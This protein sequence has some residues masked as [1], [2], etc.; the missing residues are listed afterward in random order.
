MPPS[1]SSVRFGA[2]ELD[3]RAG[4][5]RKDGVRVKLQEKPL[6]IL[7]ALL[8]QA[9]Q[10]VARDELR[11]LLWPADTFVDFEGGLN[12]AV[13]K[14]RAAL[15]D[16]AES[17]RFIET[18][19]RRGY[20]FIARVERPDLAPAMALEPPQRSSI[21]QR[22]LKLALV[23]A[24]VASAA[25]AVWAWRSR[26][27]AGAR[28]IRS[29]AV[30]PFSNFSGNA[31]EEYFVD[32][33]TEALITDLA[34]IRSLRVISRQSVMRYKGSRSSL[35]QIAKELGV[36]AVVEGSAV[37]SG[38]RVRLTAQLIDAREESHIWAHSYDRAM[39]DVLGLQDQVA[40]AIADEVRAV[41]GPEERDHLR[42]ERSAN[43]EA[44]DLYLR[45][46]YF[47]NRRTGGPDTKSTLLKA[48]GSFEQA[49]QKDPGFAV[50]YAALAETWAPLGYL[51][52]V[53]P[54]ESLEPMMRNAR[55]AEELDDRLAEAHS[56]MGACLA[57]HV[58]DWAAAEREFKRALDLNPRYPTARLWYGLYLESMGRQEENL[59]HR[60]R[61]LAD[62]PFNLVLYTG[63][64]NALALLGRYDEAIAQ[65]RRAIELDPEFEI[66]HDNLG[67]LLVDLNRYEEANAEFQKA[68][69]RL[70]VARLW[71]LRGRPAEARAL[72]AELEQ[73]AK[74]R[75]V[76]PLEPAIL[77]AALGEKDAAFACLDEAFRTRVP[78]LSHV[79]VDRVWQPLRSDPRFADLLRRM[80]LL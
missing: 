22:W 38:T 45:G 63:V 39:D 7:E 49:I 75:Y 15:G 47:F 11:T 21:L 65:Y 55:K 70:G 46:R 28:V 79:K 68:G 18:V 57:I 35:G 60:Q 66:A 56:A 1:G 6:R 48:V 44:Y 20:R 61:G 32:G 64:G 13:N 74:E 77:H 78:A 9:D 2:F 36:D 62:D 17:P 3:P 30:L 71:T 59:A 52:L 41:V 27:A 58:W 5:L 69:Q 24:G 25:A 67:T 51:G 29:L 54:A 50:A 73:A 43:P 80:K 76:S 40:S 37:R 53:A 4:E 14:L 16:S 26:S 10:V 31:D 8:A 34:S 33:M 12:T 72:L 23:L 19:G 42:R